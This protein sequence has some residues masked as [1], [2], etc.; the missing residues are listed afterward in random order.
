VNQPPP[1]RIRLR[2]PWQQEAAPE[3]IRFV[4]AFN[5]PSGLGPESHVLLAVQGLPRSA[6]VSL[7]DQRL[8]A[9]PSRKQA[10][11]AHDDLWHFDIATLL[12]AHNSLV[13]DVEHRSADFDSLA[14]GEPPAAVWLEIRD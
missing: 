5:R 3:G 11:E 2:R 1:H 10:S 6:V 8:T 13:I 14:P 9:G 12:E 7:N 4:R